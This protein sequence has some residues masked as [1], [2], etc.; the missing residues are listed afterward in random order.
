MSGAERRIWGAL[1]SS[2][3][4]QPNDFARTPARAL[5][6]AA[7]CFLVDKEVRL[8]TLVRRAQLGRPAP[9][10]SQCGE[11]AGVMRLLSEV[12]SV[13]AAGPRQGRL[14]RNSARPFRRPQISPWAFLKNGGVAELDD[15]GES[16]DSCTCR[17]VLIC[18][19][20]AQ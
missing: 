8:Y 17:D 14:L 3:C 15:W 10:V 18:V 19:H 4:R 6:P 9:G 5:S 20:G 13:L 16:P 1:L 7:D 12:L 11:E 2:L